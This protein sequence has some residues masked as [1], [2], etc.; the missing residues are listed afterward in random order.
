MYENYKLQHKLKAKAAEQEKPLFPSELL[1][2]FFYTHFL[3]MQNY[4]QT[5]SSREIMRYFPHSSSE[6]SIFP[7]GFSL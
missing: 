2:I 1:A 7:T 6:K 4:I 3:K 5:A